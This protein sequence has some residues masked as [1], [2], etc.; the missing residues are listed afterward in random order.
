MC[1]LECVLVLTH[2]STYVYIHTYMYLYVHIY[3]YI[4][5]H[6]RIT[7]LAKSVSAENSE[8]P[9]LVLEGSQF[10]PELALEVHGTLTLIWRWGTA[11]GLASG[12]RAP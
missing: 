6:E 5:R 8:F 10:T 12:R 9:Q 2:I 11:N 1:V 4:Y 3:K 7:C